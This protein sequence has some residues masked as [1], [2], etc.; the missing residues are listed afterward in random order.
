MKRHIM[1]TATVFVCWTT[2]AAAQAS[3][4]LLLASSSPPTQA[5]NAVRLN[6][7]S[8][9]ARALKASHRLAEIRARR[10]S[11]DAAATSRSL[12]DLPQVSVLAGY[13]RT[14]HVE[15]FGVPVPGAGLRVIYPDVP[16]NYRSRLDFQWPIY[17]GG[18]FDAL[19]RAAKAESQA[20]ERDLAAARADLRLEAT[21]AYWAL[22][23]A[24]ESV[25]VV[26]GALRRMDAHLADV[27][28]QLEVGLIPPNE[29]MSVQA[30]RSRQQLLVVEAESTR[31]VAIADLR[32]L[33]GIDHATP[34]ELEATLDAT[35]GRE[36]TV[37]ALVET[38]RSSRPERQ[39]FESRTAALVERRT[40]VAAA[41]RPT[42]AVAAG[43]DY[44]RPNPRIFPREERWLGSW[45]LSVNVG[46]SLWDGG[47]LRADLAEALANERAAG[48]RLAEVDTQIDFE[49]RQRVLEARAA[50]AAIPAS[51]D[52]VQSATQARRVVSERF[53]AGVATS[54]DVLDAQVALLQAELDRTRV[55]ANIKL[56]EARLDRAVGR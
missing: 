39:A 40:A 54:T 5:P 2:L 56:A 19:E 50:R 28:K 13:T 12:A 9:V 51:E 11:A 29:V 34:I 20:L 41:A 45:D 14:N 23:T 22:V 24:N 52:A 1:H 47:R 33:T 10:E 30:Q 8:V 44:A 7:Q 37:E 27:R 18:R 15:P 17:A 53:A 42:V 55:L 32:R 36:E 26:Q 21:R 31:D 4:P 25:T 35:G 48:E 49:V 6:V 43:A 46:W 3:R 16:D 38:A